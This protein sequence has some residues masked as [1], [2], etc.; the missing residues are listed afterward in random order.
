MADCEVRLVTE[1][2]MLDV[3]SALFARPK[4]REPSE[5]KARVVEWTAIGSE[6][7]KVNFQKQYVLLV[8]PIF[9]VRLFWPNLPRSVR[10]RRTVRCQ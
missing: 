2:Q 10:C 6:T 9:L 7:K 4:V 5:E 3:L 8:L 1:D